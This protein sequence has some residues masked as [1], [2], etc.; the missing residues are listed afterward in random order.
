MISLSQKDYQKNKTGQGTFALKQISLKSRGYTTTL[1]NKR[2]IQV[3][4][5]SK[6]LI[7]N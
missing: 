1:L 4:A 6:F 7:T 2:M 3:Q 5:I